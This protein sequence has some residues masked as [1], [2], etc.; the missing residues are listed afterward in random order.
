MLFEYEFIIMPR[1]KP[2]RMKYTTSVSLYL[3]QV[4]QIEKTGI[5]LSQYIREL[6]DA[7]FAREVLPEERAELDKLF[8]NADV[9]HMATQTR[10]LVG[11]M[12]TKGFNT[13]P[14]TIQKYIADKIAI[15]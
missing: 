1:P 4:N 8:E 7:T 2:S 12:R 10:S 9:E 11:I 14:A 15:T 13:S 5:P 3:D 6:L